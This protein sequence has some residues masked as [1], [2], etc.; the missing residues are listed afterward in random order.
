[1]I[2]RPRQGWLLDCQHRVGIAPIGRQCHAQ[3]DHQVQRQ[4]VMRASGFNDVH[5]V[6]PV[7]QM[8]HVQQIGTLF[9]RHGGRLQGIEHLENRIPNDFHALEKQA[10]FAA[11]ADPQIHR[12][13]LTRLDVLGKG[14]V[15]RVGVAK[16]RA[17]QNEIRRTAVAD[18]MTPR[19][20]HGLRHIAFSRRVDGRI[21]KIAPVGRR[22]CIDAA[23]Y[24][25]CWRRR[26]K[27]IQ[28]GDGI[29]RIRAVSMQRQV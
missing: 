23:D 11:R 27:R 13:G 22:R 20:V 25:Y 26:H 6:I 15:R 1:V 24:A 10:C 4:H 9:P 29:R 16:G 2:D 7:A 28:T 17:R 3:N 18:A 12:L 8:T 5:L 14:N 21:G 19:L